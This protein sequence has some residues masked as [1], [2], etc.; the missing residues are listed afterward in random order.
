MDQDMRALLL[1]LPDH[2]LARLMFDHIEH[3][4]G[5]GGHFNPPIPD[6]LI[7]DLLTSPQ[8]PSASARDAAVIL[9]AALARERD[10]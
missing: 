9:R 6:C 2:L 4:R 3:C 5:P 1:A 7:Q 8:H 10:C